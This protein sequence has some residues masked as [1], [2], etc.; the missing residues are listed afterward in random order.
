MCGVSDRY[1][2][3]SIAAFILESG[4]PLP[5]ASFLGLP[6]LFSLEKWAHI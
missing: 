4:L 5:F 1:I 3:W 6:G 2:F